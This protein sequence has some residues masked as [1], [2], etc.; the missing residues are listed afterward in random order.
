MQVGY[1][2]NAKMIT[3]KSTLD[4]FGKPQAVLAIVM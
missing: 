2:D 1:F 3:V 4:R